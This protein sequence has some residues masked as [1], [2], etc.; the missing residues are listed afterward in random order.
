[1]SKPNLKLTRLGKAA[2]II[3]TLF[4]CNVFVSD[5]L[6]SDSI[7]IQNGLLYNLLTFSLFFWLISAILILFTIW[8]IKRENKKKT[9]GLSSFLLMIISMVSI[10]ISSIFTIFTPPEMSEA[11]VYRN[12]ND[13]TDK[14]IYEFYLTG[15]TSDSPN[16]KIIRTKNQDAIIRKVEV[17]KDSIL[18][19]NFNISSFPKE[20]PMIRNFKYKDGS[21]T[22][23]SYMTW[24]DWNKWTKYKITH[25]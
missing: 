18:I 25:R 8:N 19:E 16:W 5:Y 13:P 12:E 3:C 9:T 2:I 23:E 15:I 24:E 7:E 14:I 4:I 21:Y 6:S 1:M 17:L 10:I 11:I 20:P 22:L